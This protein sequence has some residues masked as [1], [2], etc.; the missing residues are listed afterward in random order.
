VLVVGVVSAR[1]EYD[2][3]YE[4]VEYYIQ[5]VKHEVSSSDYVCDFN[6]SLQSLSIQC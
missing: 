6:Q 3:N 2:V 1:G 4:C 5:S